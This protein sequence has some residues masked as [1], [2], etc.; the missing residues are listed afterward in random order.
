MDC[1]LAVPSKHRHSREGGN[2]V[3]STFFGCPIMPHGTFS[4]C[5]IHLEPGVTCGMF[6]KHN[7]LIALTSEAQGRVS[8]FIL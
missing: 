6:G 4:A 3:F 2:P 1:D 5:G 8:T 7:K